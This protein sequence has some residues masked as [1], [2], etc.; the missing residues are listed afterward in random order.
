MKKIMMTMAQFAKGMVFSAVLFGMAA[1]AAAQDK[2]LVMWSH[3]GEEPAK[4]NFI[5]A[6]AAEFQKTTGIA[7]EVVWIPKKELIDKLPF[8]LDS[9][10]PDITYLDHGFTHPRINRSLADLSDL[11]FDAQF[12]PSWKLLSLGFEGKYKN[13]LPIEGLSNAIYY[14][15]D[16][17]QQAGI[18]L[19]QDHHLT[20]VEFLEIVKKLRAAGITPIGEGASD[21]TVKAGL[22]IINTLFRYIGPEKMAKLLKG[23]IN[24]SDPD[25]VAGL[26]FWKQVV[27]AQGYDK[28][29]ANA[30]GMVEGI[31][32]VTDGRAAM[33]FCGTFFYSKYAATEHDRGNIGVLDWFQVNG[34]KGNDWHEISWVAGYGANAHSAHL[35]DAKRFLEFLMTPT[36]AALWA[37]YVQAPYPVAADALTEQSLFGQLTAQR[38]GQQPAPEGFTYQN[39]SEKAAQNMWEDTTRRFISGEF[40]VEQFIERMNSRL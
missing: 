10:E 2:K 4:V 1:N 32:E 3:W 17:F 27:D 24:F 18:T 9:A 35:A 34:G 22:P 38:K 29:K 20:E 13:F 8:A 28:D 25:V 5:K 11:T 14:N 40:T 23:D 26:T 31:F 36:A 7:L 15:R 16:L 12:D 37:Q 30:L 19:P 33:N 39:F 6:V 21:R